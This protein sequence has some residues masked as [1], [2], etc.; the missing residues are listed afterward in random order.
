[1]AVALLGEPI[2]PYHAAAL[3]LV[4]GGIL[5]AQRTPR[6]LRSEAARPVSGD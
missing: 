6:A 2:A 5:L 3:A 1:M 4:I